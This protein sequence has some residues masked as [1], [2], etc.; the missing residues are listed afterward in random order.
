MKIFILLV[1]EKV[2]WNKQEN[3][4]KFKLMLFFFQ[5]QENLNKKLESQKSKQ[6]K[7]THANF[8]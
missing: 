4:Y 1:E 2:K 5:E 6:E 3:S 8:Q 7:V